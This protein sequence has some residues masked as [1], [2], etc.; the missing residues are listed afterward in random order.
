MA[1]N[2]DKEHP[3][4]EEIKQE[5]FKLVDKGWRYEAKGMKFVAADGGVYGLEEILMS[6]AEYSFSVFSKKEDVEPFADRLSAALKIV[7]KAVDEYQKSKKRKVRNG[8]LRRKES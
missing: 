2:F 6:Y 8:L 4:L 5:A 3:H 7:S 1:N